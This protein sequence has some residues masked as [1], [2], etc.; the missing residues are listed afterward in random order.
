MRPGFT[1]S[2]PRATVGGVEIARRAEL[3]LE[4]IRKHDFA[5]V[6][7]F[8][9]ALV[10]ALDTAAVDL[11]VMAG[12]LCLWHLPER[13]Q[14]RVLNIHPARLPSFGGRGMHGHHVH[15]AVLAAGVPE[16]GCTV[17]LADNEYDH[18]PIVAQA[19]VPIHP[20]DSPDSLAARVGRAERELYPDVIQNV[21]D[22]GLPWL[23]QQVKLPR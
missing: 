16:S 19:R 22:H 6:S 11:V 4:I 20:D 10:K 17:H 2:S 8:S 13:Y 21:A 7:A 5:D 23:L 3:P 15:E 1:Q 18:G 9:D 14:G 12:F